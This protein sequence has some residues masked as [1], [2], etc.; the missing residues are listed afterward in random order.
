M[1]CLQLKGG[2]GNQ[3]FQYAFGVT[4]S[5]KLKSDLVFDLSFN[6]NIPKAKGITNRSFQLTIFN[7]LPIEISKNDLRKLKPLF[8]R[9][10]NTIAT[11]IGINGIQTSSYFLEKQY[12]Y[13]KRINIIS[14]NC[15]LSGYWQSYYYFESIEPKIRELFTF[16]SDL[17]GENLNRLNLIIGTNSVS[18]HIRRTD[19]LNNKSHD[20]HGSCSLTYY[21]DA[22][23]LVNSK[24]QSPHYFIFSDDIEWVKENDLFSNLQATFIFGNIMDKSYIDMQLM[25]NCK[26][27]IIANSSFSWWGAWLNGNPDKLVVAPKQ[28]FL[29]AEL[30]KQTNDLIPQKWVRI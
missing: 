2:L 27:N 6:D 23:E 4:M 14:S 5:Y 28:W 7:I 16:K 19:F 12:G 13:N 15:Y 18:I 22:I 3:M 30:N 17:N 26:H 1:I 20:I 29:N 25:S 21:K 9:V 24:I 8:N 11:K 10:V